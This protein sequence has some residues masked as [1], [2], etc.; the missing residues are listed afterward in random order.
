MMS[1]RQLFYFEH[2]EAAASATP[3]PRLM[4]R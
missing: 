4:T 1:Q 2:A 3:K